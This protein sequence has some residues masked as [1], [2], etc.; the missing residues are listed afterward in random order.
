[1]TR[2]RGKPTLRLPPIALATSTVQF[3]NC[4]SLH[5]PDGAGGVY[6]CYSCYA[7]SITTLTN[8]TCDGGGMYVT[9]AGS[10]ATIK[11]GSVQIL[12]LCRTLR[13]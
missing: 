3:N 10:T 7:Q 4:S 5:M 6:N 1:M 12:P 11:G 13:L 2:W 9:D 8:F